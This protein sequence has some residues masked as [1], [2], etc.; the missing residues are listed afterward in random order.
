MQVI[1]DTGP[2]IALID[3]SEAMHKKCIEWLRQFEGVIF[4][5]E[6]ALTEFFICLIFRSRPNWQPSILC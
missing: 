5:S 6:A 3:R 1:M 2:W 4:S